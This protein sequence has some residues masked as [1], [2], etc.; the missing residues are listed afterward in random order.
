MKAKFIYEVFT[1]DSDPIHDLGIGIYHE[2]NFN[3]AEEAFDFM[4]KVIPAV[5]NVKN[6]KDIFNKKWDGDN[7]VI[8]TPLYK[9]INNYYLKYVRVNGR[10]SNLLS[11][12]FKE[13]LESKKLY[14]V[15]TENSDPIIDLGIG[16]MSTE[17]KKTFNRIFSE[18]GKLDFDFSDDLK[19][20]KVFIP[21]KTRKEALKILDILYK[22]RQGY[23]GWTP[24]PSFFDDRIDVQVMDILEKYKRA[25]VKDQEYRSRS[26]KN[27]SQF[28]KKDKGIIYDVESWKEN[29]DPEREW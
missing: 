18:F 4:Y 3:S 22:G 21:Y 15:F 2:F 19:Y 6:T 7:G 23:K 28:H 29:N 24:P 1:D 26:Y 17:I 16:G 14:E 20:I 13:Y 25:L 10:I 11:L 12:D 27:K 5:A 8:H 9:I